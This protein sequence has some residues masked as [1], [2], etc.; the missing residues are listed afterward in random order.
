MVELSRLGTLFP[1]SSRSVMHKGEKMFLEHYFDKYSFQPDKA[2]A[3]GFKKMDGIFEYQCP[4]LSGSFLLKMWIKAKEVSF[5]VYDQDTGDEYIQIHLEQLQGH[6]VGQV[7]EACQETLAAI[8]Q[9]C[10]EVEDFLYPQAKRLMNYIS[11]RFQG[12]IEYLWERSPE[13][14]TIR[15][16]DTLKWYGVFMAI[17][18]K[19]L[20]AGKSGNIEVLNVKTNQAADLTHEKGIYPA[21]HMNKKYWVSIPLDNTLADEELFSLVDRSWQLTKKGK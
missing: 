3:Y 11:Q 8:R 2:Q 7:R 12:R 13:S 19:K 1:A 20:D 21:F 17:D 4:V 18:W 6:F 5:K 10:F 16:R 14:G 15:H 9:S